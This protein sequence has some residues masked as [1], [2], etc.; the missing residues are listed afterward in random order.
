MASN[1]TVVYYRRTHKWNGAKSQT[2]GWRGT[3]ARKGTSNC[4]P[5][6]S[7]KVLMQSIAHLKAK[8]IAMSIPTNIDPKI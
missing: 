5:P 3:I 2:N 1:L 4:Q 7:N 6:E 8:P